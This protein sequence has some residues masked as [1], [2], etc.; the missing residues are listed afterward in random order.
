MTSASTVR[1][2]QGSPETSGSCRPCSVHL[3]LEEPAEPAAVLLLQLGLRPVLA[4]HG[5][6]APGAAAAALHLVVAVVGGGPV[7][8]ELLA[9]SDVP[10]RDQDDLALDG[11]V[12]IAAMVGV[13]HAA[14]AV[15]LADRGDE[16]IL[17]D[18]DVG[19]PEHG[20]EV[21]P[22]P[23]REHV[24]ALDRDDL[25][26]RDRLLGEEALAVDRARPYL[27]LRRAVR[28]ISHGRPLPGRRRP[29]GLV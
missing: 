26:P 6:A 9:G 25:A 1:Q 27:A 7:D 5:A 10:H 2:V 22:L 18:L 23:S 19:G 29:A 24:A 20:L 8:R 21:G 28:E 13:E 11:Q 4:G 14:V 15:V 16:E 12:G 17:R 3:P